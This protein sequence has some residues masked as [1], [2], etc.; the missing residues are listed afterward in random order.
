MNTAPY[1]EIKNSK[2]GTTAFFAI[3]L[4]SIN[5][6][7]DKRDSFNQ[8][9]LNQ[10]A[11]FIAALFGLGG[12]TA[13]ELRYICHPHNK[14][15]YRGSIDLVLRVRMD[16]EGDRDA[17]DHARSLYQSVIPNVL[18]ISM[19]YQWEAVT[20]R[21]DYHRYFCEKNN[22]NVKELVR[23]E[24]EILLNQT[25]ANPSRLPIGF[26]KDANL[27]T[28]SE[29]RKDSAYVCFPYTR[30]SDTLERL[31]YELLYQQEITI[32]SICLRPTRANENEYKFL[33]DQLQ[34]AERF[35]QLPLDGNV[36]D[37]S[38]F[39]PSLQRQSII[40]CEHL[41]QS[42]NAMR[43]DM[44]FTT[45]HVFSSRPVSRMLCESIGVAFT[46][47]VHSSDTSANLGYGQH[48]TILGGGFDWLEPTT[49]SERK[50]AIRNLHSMS[51]AC[52]TPGLL[53]NQKLRLRRLFDINQANCVFRLPLPLEGDF[54]GIATQRTKQIPAP[55]TE[56]AVR[57][58]KN[59][60]QSFTEEVYFKDID[61]LRHTY[62][63]GKTGTGK[64]TLLKSLIMQD[65]LAGNGVGV[66]DPHGELV[67]DLLQ[68]I[69]PE[70]TKDVVL[71]D[72]E[73]DD[74]FVGLNLLDVQSELEKD[75][76]VNYLLEVFIS[77]FNNP[78]A[79]GPMFEMYYR[80]GMLLTMADESNPPILMDLHRVFE[81][82][83]YRREKLR[84]CKDPHVTRFWLMALR[85]G[86]EAS[87]ENIAPYITSKLVRITH[88]HIMRMICCQR[89]STIDFED[90][91]EG[92]RILLVNLSKGSLGD[93]TSY[94]LGM[95]LVKMLQTVAFRRDSGGPRQPPTPFYLYVDEFHNLATP[96][97]AN[98]LSESRKY[99]LAVTV[100]NQYMGQLPENIRD[101]IIGNI[102][103]T[104]SFRVGS[105]DAEALEKSFSPFVSLKDFIN[106]PNFNAYASMLVD[107]NMRR[108]FN[109]RIERVDFPEHKGSYDAIIQGMQNYTRLK[110]E[111]EKSL[112]I[113]AE[114]VDQNG[115]RSANDAKA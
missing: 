95:M 27:S 102:G 1:I 77:I 20:A 89:K 114:A 103:S 54:P 63:L 92:R 23:R 67:E 21:D 35:I 50:R 108:P 19:N 38:F 51:D 59:Q 52:L 106:L 18:S 110:T 85:A 9:L 104:I 64:S 66:L 80:N 55:V 46:E 17:H 60:Y 99:G 70:R 34:Q 44:F 2:A 83:K 16:V 107:G 71:I 113:K 4:T 101:S 49:D 61:R 79:F 45:V 58:G 28:S 97:F 6:R 94:F 96:T 43:D 41:R 88:S 37:P 33:V 15:P 42:L 22:W 11:D 39:F 62:I 8:I 32:I 69:P 53:G 40:V 36:S 30:S 14:S 31:F 10:Q 100:A 26:T 82:A 12:D 73:R 93:T 105:E 81:D 29:T 86:G 91:I 98:L 25:S 74:R 115:S 111:I 90:V 56:G 24:R 72:P 7:S 76:L 78:E 3:R 112:N 109:L 47:H 87:L 5:T 13:I 68:L 84:T 57:I 65:V 75:S 48:Q